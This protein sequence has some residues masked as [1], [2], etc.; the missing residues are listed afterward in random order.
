MLRYPDLDWPTLINTAKAMNLQNKLG[1]VTRL[2]RK[3]AESGETDKA[4][5][6]RNQEKVLERLRLLLEDTLCNDP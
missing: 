6:L 4:N 2:A 1:F 5:F 3:V